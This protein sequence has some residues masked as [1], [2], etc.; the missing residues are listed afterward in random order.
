MALKIDAKFEEKL[1]Y[2]FK[3]VK[4][5]VNFDPSTQNS[6]NV[7]LVSSVKSIFHDTRD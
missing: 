1:I 2:C 6:Q 7:L 5:L 3:T 4:N